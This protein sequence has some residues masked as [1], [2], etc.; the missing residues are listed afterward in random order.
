MKCSYKS[1]PSILTEIRKDV[2]NFL[3][4]KSDA[5]TVSNVVIAIN[6]ACMN[7]IQHA[8]DGKYKG[9]IELI[10]SVSGSKFEVCIE[11]DA[12]LI[13]PELLKGRDIDVIEPGGLGL[14]FMN[15]I[16]D[17]VEFDIGSN[18]KG[19]KLTMVKSI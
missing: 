7:I 9:N 3:Q 13:N 16:M 18:N 15:D 8:N 4:N 11:D 5:D 1:D 14:F 12:S 6:E 17:T 2:R 10:L 19:N